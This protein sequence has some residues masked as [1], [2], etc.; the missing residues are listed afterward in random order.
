MKKIIIILTYLFT[1]ISSI[2]SLIEDDKINN[3]NEAFADHDL[4]KIKNILKDNNKLINIKLFEDEWSPLMYFC[5]NTEEY[6]FIEYLLLNGANVNY[7]DNGG[8]TALMLASWNNNL[9]IV[10][11][12]IKYGAD[13][14]I[15]ADSD[16]WAPIFNY[17]HT[18][19]SIARCNDADDVVS[20]LESIGVME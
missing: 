8:Y 12:L 20:Y 15:K 14:N 7:Q 13:C 1:L 19:L 18:A 11:L 10:K 2:Y 9:R 16:S 5:M 17:N 6:E 3:L 4:S